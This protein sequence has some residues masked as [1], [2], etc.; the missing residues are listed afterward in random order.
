MRPRTSLARLAAG[1]RAISFNKFTLEDTMPLVKPGEDFHHYNGSEAFVHDIPMGDGTTK[2][3]LK[4]KINT[5]VISER[6]AVPP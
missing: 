3:Y 2:R 1:I 6:L 4:F 5:L